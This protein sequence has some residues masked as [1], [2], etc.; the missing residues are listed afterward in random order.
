MKNKNE[1]SQILPRKIWEGKRKF[2]I[3]VFDSGFGGLDILR[4]IVKELP[5]YSYIYLGD[6]SRSPYGSRSPETVHLFT[7]QAIDT[8]ILGC[9]HYGILKE[10]IKKEIGKNIT[11]VAEGRVAAEKLKD[12]LKR[13][14]EIE[15]KL[16]KKGKISFLT[17]GLAG[18][19]KI[20]GSRFFGRKISSKKVAIDKL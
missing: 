10:K 20:F 17:T 3:G 1:P 11:A 14:P 16:L 5:E 13:H 8:L 4:E 19:F 18:K 2:F 15:R 6:T 12:Y 9:T 7:K